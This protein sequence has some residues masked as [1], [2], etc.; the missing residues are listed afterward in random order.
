MGDDPVPNA[1]DLHYV[2]G[3]LQNHPKDI[4]NFVQSNTDD[5]AVKDFMVKLKKHLL[6]RIQQIHR[7]NKCMDMT[8]QTPRSSLECPDNDPSLFAMLT[9]VIFKGN[10]IFWHNICQINYTTYDLRREMETVNPNCDHRDVML[11]AD[12]DG[13]TSHPFSYARVLGI[14]HANVIYTGPTARDY[15]SRRIEFL[16][17]RWFEVTKSPAGYDHCALDKVKFVPMARSDTFGFVDP[18]DVLRCCHL[19]P[20]YAKGRLHPDG[21]EISRSARDSE[22]WKFYYINRF[23]DRDMVMR[24]H[25]GMSVGH[26]YAYTSSPSNDSDG[27]QDEGHLGLGLADTTG[28]SIGLS[29]GQESDE[30][31][32]EDD[33]A[34]WAEMDYPSDED[35]DDADSDSDV[36]VDAMY[37]LDEGEDFDGYRG[38]KF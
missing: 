38:Y 14:Y 31:S 26:A 8:L 30:E 34:L 3:K 28:A 11:L 24:Y 36:L 35:N 4:T 15:L 12:T 2:I 22:D 32:Q 5:P 10:R 25:W 7:E 16:W 23:V 13:T 21:A 17:V 27:Q 6:P 33:S 18:S 37:E 1:P 19:I 20:A 29:M 9:Q